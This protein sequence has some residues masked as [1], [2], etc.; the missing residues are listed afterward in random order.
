M[1]KIIDI[2]DNIVAKAESI[3]NL[4]H[5]GF[6]LEIDG[7]T[8]YWNGKNLANNIVASGV[9]LVILS[10]LDTFETRVLKLM[11]IR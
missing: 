5:R 1:K 10:D 9:Y 11:V 6:N 4:R 7:G 2:E 3:R 8:V